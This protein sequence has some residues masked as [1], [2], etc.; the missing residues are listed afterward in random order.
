MN[1]Y[2]YSGD[3]PTMT[4]L[5]A[6]NV[7]ANPTSAVGLMDDPVPVYF[8]GPLTGAQANGSE[9]SAELDL[10][11]A[12]LY[13]NYAGSGGSYVGSG[14]GEGPPG[15]G[16]VLCAVSSDSLVTLSGSGPSN[17]RP[18]VTGTLTITNCPAS[19]AGKWTVV[20]FNDGLFVGQQVSGASAG[21]VIGSTGALPGSYSITVY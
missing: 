19:W 13:S 21:F 1:P 6:S 17:T 15:G 10:V 4:A 8:G 5:G 11:S 20:V 18:G 7:V 12:T 16:F 2:E 14:N 9:S 3:N